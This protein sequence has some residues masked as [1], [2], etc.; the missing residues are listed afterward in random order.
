MVIQVSG[1]LSTQVR[2]AAAR[3]EI[4]VLAGERLDS[5]EAT[6]IDSL[7]TGNTRDTL[8]VAGVRYERRVR[9]RRITAVLLQI[10]V[11]MTAIDGNGPSYE[12][13]SYHSGIW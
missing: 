2:Y 7:S 9:V 6:P 3:S 1:A 11:W 8:T 5:L 10:D 12:A 13:T 4:A